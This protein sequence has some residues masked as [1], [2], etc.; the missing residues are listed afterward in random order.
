MVNLKKKNYLKKV[1][2]EK[3]LVYYGFKKSHKR[4]DESLEFILKEISSAVV[5]PGKKS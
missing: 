1:K 2:S 4:K 3:G 5:I